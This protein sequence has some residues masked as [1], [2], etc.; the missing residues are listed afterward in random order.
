M[1][2]KKISPSIFLL[3]FI[4][5]FLPFAEISCNGNLVGSVTTMNLVTGTQLDGKDVSSEPIA[6]L[7]LLIVIGGIVVGF[8]KNRKH[9]LGLIFSIAGFILNLL[10]R[11]GITNKV[12]E[13][14]K[15][16][17]DISYGIGFYLPL[18]LFISAIGVNA[19]ALKEETA[20]KNLC[21]SICGMENSSESNSCIHCNGA[22][23]G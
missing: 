3:V 12:M 5:L 21:C 18:L 23:S 1:K 2:N 15:G 20:S 6:I 8:I 19:Y 17:F 11:S 7:L 9:L 4:C 14:G 16:I 10:L 22:L 13:Q